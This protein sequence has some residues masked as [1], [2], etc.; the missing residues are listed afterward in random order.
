MTQSSSSNPFRVEIQPARAIPP[1]PAWVP[2]P[3]YFADV[4]ALNYPVDVTPSIYQPGD[5]S[6]L[7][8]HWTGSAVVYDFSPLGAQVFYGAGHETA[9]GSPNIQVTLALDFSTLRW[10]TQNVPVAANPKSAFEALLGTAPDGTPYSPHTYLGLQEMPRAWG[11][12][13][14]GSLVRLNMAGTG[15]TPYLQNI[16]SADLSQTTNGY[17]LMMMSGQSGPAAGP[18]QIKFSASTTGGSYP[19]SVQ[20]N[21]RQGWWLDVNGQHDYTLFISK[22]G[23]VTQTPALH[24]NNSWAA[25]TLWESKNLLVLFNG[26]SE[27]VARTMRV[28]DL[29]TNVTRDVQIVG[30]VPGGIKQPDDTFQYRPE[31]LG[32]QWVEELGCVVGLDF[33]SS[34]PTICKITPPASDPQASAWTSSVVNLVHW[35]AGDPSGSTQMRFATNGNFSKFRWVKTLGAFVLATSSTSKPQVFSL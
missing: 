28:R 34:P 23:A 25:M 10:S 5:M 7:F 35:D 15:G 2:P 4:P 3:G 8:D 21:G 31:L 26:G 1:R 19:V 12:G 20:D 17:T 27:S 24:G 9:D 11:G 6:A 13:P 33:Q 16:A 22:S 18:N 29:T 32:L 14:K 30:T